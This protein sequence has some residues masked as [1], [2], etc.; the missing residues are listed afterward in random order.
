MRA[1]LDTLGVPSYFLPGSNRVT[2][3]GAEHRA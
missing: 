3:R 1:I 2:R